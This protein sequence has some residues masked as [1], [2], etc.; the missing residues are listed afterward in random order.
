MTLAQ[1]QR[2]LK[3]LG[4]PKKA[5]F[6]AGYFK[7]G[8]GEYGEGDIFLGLTVPAQRLLA[9]RYTHLPLADIIKLLQS[10]I[11]E[12]RLVALLLLTH[13]YEQ[14]NNKLKTKIFQLYLKNTK[15]INN[16]DLVD[17]S[18]SYIVGDY[19]LNRP[20]QVLYKLARSNSLWE[21][22]IAI[23]ATFAFIRQGQYTDTLKL[24]K[25]LLRDS[26][27]LIHK[28]TGWALREVGKKDR[29]SL[30][31]FLNANASTMPRTALRYS[32]EH[33]PEKQRRYY[34]IR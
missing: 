22:R 5:K 4:S 33:L 31:R 34:M 20:R 21:R 27:D 24:A 16:W 10:K 7:T 12:Q 13:Q 11:H 26:H 2:D 29:P 8:K 6:V 15:H 19:L 9:K 14:G 1:L 32:L 28:A 30:I 25:L 23:I 18:A 3:S 17:G